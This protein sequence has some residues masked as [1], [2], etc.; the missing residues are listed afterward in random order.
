M[1]SSPRPPNRQSGRPSTEQDAPT[2][3]PTVDRIAEELIACFQT[4]RTPNN[5]QAAWVAW[6]VLKRALTQLVRDDKHRLMYRLR[7]QRT[8]ARP[9]GVSG[10]GYWS[11]K[12]VRVE[13]HPAVENTGIVFIRADLPQRPR[14]PALV[15]YRVETPRRSSLECDGARVEM[16]E[17][18]MAALAGMRIDNCQVLVTAPEMPGC[19]GS[20]LPFVQVLKEA[21][22][23][24]QSALRPVRVVTRVIRV[25]E[26]D[27][28]FEVRP[29][30]GEEFFLR[31]LLDYGPKGPIGRQSFGLLFS[32]H[33][34][35]RELAP[36]RT[37]MLK[38]E[39]DWLLSQGLGKRTTT[40]DLLVFGDAEPIDNQL[41]FPDECAR[42]KLMDM[43]GDLALAGCDLAGRFCAY[44]SGH[45][46]NA[47]LTRSILAQTEA[48]DTVRRCA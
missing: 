31:Y 41:R 28:W 22:I 20:S 35:A 23:V 7:K 32:S 19:D 14:I 43:I 44:R 3:R 33:A 39:A 26:G 24:E 10:F 46:L 8:I 11:G 36:C 25:E 48:V 45:R 42:H 13:F 17:H 15:Q 12:D 38:S 47:S 30:M 37:F 5:P 9:G 2:G 4:N 18:I 1:T 16:V 27:A 21:G 6:V 34:F 40:K 29:G